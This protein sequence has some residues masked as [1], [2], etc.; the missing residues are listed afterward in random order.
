MLLPPYPPDNTPGISL[1]HCH[2]HS[3]ILSA[4]VVK[5]LFFIVECWFF[6]VKGLCPIGNWGKYSGIL[7]EI[8][9]F[10]LADTVVF[11]ANTLGSWANIMIFVSDQCFF[12]GNY[13]GNFC[14]YSGIVGKYS[15]ILG[16]YSGIWVNTVGR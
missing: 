7:G 9:Q 4:N 2:C 6:M 13:S 16:K 15:G 14:Q 12:F 3:Q 10:L 1:C 8:Q 5:L 11:W